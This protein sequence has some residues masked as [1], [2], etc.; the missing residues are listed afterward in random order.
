MAKSESEISSVAARYSLLPKPPDT[1]SRCQYLYL[2]QHVV[3][4]FSVH[5]SSCRANHLP[6]A[7]IIANGPLSVWSQRVVFD[8]TSP[9]SLAGPALHTTHSTTTEMPLRRAA[10]LLNGAP[11]TQAPCGGES[12]S[13]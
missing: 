12:T 3:A 5:E 10:D 6:F 13:C 1:V 2:A 8:T 7:I 9:K 11:H 4:H